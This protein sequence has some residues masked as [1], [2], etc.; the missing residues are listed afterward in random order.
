M[1]ETASKGIFSGAFINEMPSLMAGSTTERNAP[2]VQTL[3]D[4]HAPPR[5]VNMLRISSPVSPINKDPSDPFVFFAITP[6]VNVNKPANRIT[7][8]L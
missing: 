2:E 8:N 1:R 7:N 6:R 4:L 5:D 3:G